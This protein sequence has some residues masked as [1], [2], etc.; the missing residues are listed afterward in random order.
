[1]TNATNAKMHDDHRL[2][3]SEHSMWMDD[4]QLWRNEHTKMLTEF[5]NVHELLQQHQVALESH[6]EAIQNHEKADGE[7]EL[8]LAGQ[9]SGAKPTIGDQMTKTHLSTAKCHAQQREDHERIKRHH[10]SVI[11]RWSLL[12]KGMR[13]SA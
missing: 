2:W 8:E 7:H 3:N 1:M 10:H 9:E 5:Q 4:I 11:A 12:L 13:E 6:C